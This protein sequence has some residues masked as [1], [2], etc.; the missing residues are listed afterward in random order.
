MLDACVLRLQADVC[1]SFVAAAKGS[2][3]SVSVLGVFTPRD[4]L[5]QTLERDKPDMQV[6]TP[7]RFPGKLAVDAAG[8][9]V[10]VADTSNNRVLVCGLDGTFQSEI[11]GVG[12]GLRDGA[13]EDAA[14]D[15]PQGLAYDARRDALYVADTENHAVRKVD[16]AARR[17][18]TLAGDGSQGSDYAGGRAGRAQQLSSPWDVATS[19][20]GDELVVAM[21]GQHQIW[22]VSLGMGRCQ[23][24]SGNGAERNQNGSHGGNTSWA[25]PSGLALRADGAAMCALC[26]HRAGSSASGHSQRP[27]YALLRLNASS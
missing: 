2:Y 10:F 17:V 26:L 25:Q 4:I 23:A 22:R 20:D 13:F 24:F 6:A 18:S 8:R 21:S 7:L 27:A 15:H 14:F 11:G 5:V 1:P 12:T 3:C 9:R 19:A 16:L